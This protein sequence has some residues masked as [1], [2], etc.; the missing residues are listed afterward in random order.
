MMEVR[1]VSTPL[2]LHPPLNPSSSTAAEESHFHIGQPTSPQ[3][4]QP[5]SW[6]KYPCLAPEAAERS[7]TPSSLP[8]PPSLAQLSPSVQH[9]ALP[10]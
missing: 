10:A 8:T 1:A 5:E 6:N 4:S 3:V 9:A 2:T 7:P